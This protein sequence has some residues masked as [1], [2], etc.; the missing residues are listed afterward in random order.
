MTGWTTTQLPITVSPVGGEAIDSWIEAYARRLL[1]C[2]RG[3][4]THLGLTGSQP[5]QMITGLT[6]AERQALS[7]ATAVSATQ[8]GRMTLVRYDGIAVT[9]DHARPPGGGTPAADTARPA[10]TRTADAGS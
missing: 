10:C 6:A 1:T 3:L 8:L 7:A 5:R 9:I 4:L 2:S